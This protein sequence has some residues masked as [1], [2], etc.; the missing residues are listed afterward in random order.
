MNIQRLKYL[1]KRLGLSVLSL[2]AVATFLFLAFRLVP[3]DPTTAV[4]APHM[5]DQAR[6]ELAAQYGLTQPL[7]IQYLRFLE[8]I[9]TFQLG[10]SF[11]YSS[12]VTEIIKNRLVNTLLLMVTS[13]T[14]AY[15]LGII[16]GAFFA[17]KRDTKVDTIGIGL[18]LVMYAA[19]VFWTGML[20]LMIFSFRLEWVPTGG[21]HSV[22]FVAESFW[23]D[24]LSVDFL[25]HLILPV[26]VTTLYYLSVPALTMR[27]NLL[28]VLR[29]DFIEM[30]RA[31]GLSNFSILYRHAAR[32]ALLPVL[33][34]AAVSLGFAI[35]GSVI[36]EKV[37]SWPGL[38]RLMWQAT[39]A[40]DYP[41][42]Q[43]SFLMLAA[44]VI[45]LNFFAD[46]LSAYVDPRVAVD[47]TQVSSNE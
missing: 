21:A 45:L 35:G 14:L 24:Y 28:D 33:H 5:S 23:D 20:A 36:I 15:V 26:V 12:P 30:M 7:H 3:G 37:F 25:H 16:I 42:A 9:V 29:E 13:V 10:T 4:I 43:Y 44:I 22:T 19:P 11:Q 34:Y 38:G 41:L 2:W 17:W 46:V 39:L 47:Q 8:N 1:L 18:V 6:Q 27:N 40:Q 32:N 31:A